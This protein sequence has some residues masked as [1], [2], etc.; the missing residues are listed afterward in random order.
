MLISGCLVSLSASAAALLGP[1][2]AA[3]TAPGLPELPSS[4][5]S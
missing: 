3:V 4:S 1:T 5:S 2:L